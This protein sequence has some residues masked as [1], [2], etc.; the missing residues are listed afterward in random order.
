MGL[1]NAPLVRAMTIFGIKA[2]MIKLHEKRKAELEN[3]LAT[4]QYEKVQAK[5]EEKI[6]EKASKQL[7]IEKVEEKES[8]IK[9]FMGWLFR[10]PVKEIKVRV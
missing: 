8:G 9:R 3:A 5:V 4:G 7:P 6:Q 2:A 1:E 10:N